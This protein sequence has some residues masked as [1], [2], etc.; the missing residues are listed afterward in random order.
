[1]INNKN[2]GS[3]K[4]IVTALNAKLNNIKIKNLI[5]I[6]K[7]SRNKEIHKYKNIEREKIN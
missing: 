2:Y 4:V 5:N 1:M 6:E 7:V 3:N